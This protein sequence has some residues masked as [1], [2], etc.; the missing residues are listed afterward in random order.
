MAGWETAHSPRREY[1]RTAGP[2]RPRPQ[3][4]PTRCMSSGRIPIKMRMVPDQVNLRRSTV[5]A[6]SADGRC[7]ADSSARVEQR[8]NAENSDPDDRHVMHGYV[9]ACISIRQK[10]ALLSA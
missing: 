3:L 7:I 5:S 2:T 10:C 1:A 6:S 8:R 9:Q 4:S